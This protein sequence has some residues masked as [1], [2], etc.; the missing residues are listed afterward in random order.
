MTGASPA[1]IFFEL[2]SLVVIVGILK[3]FFWDL[4]F[5]DNWD[6]FRLDL[7]ETAESLRNQNKV[8]R[9]DVDTQG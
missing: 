7:H 9:D 3:F 4:M 5:K 1:Q 8:Q 2:I 6:K